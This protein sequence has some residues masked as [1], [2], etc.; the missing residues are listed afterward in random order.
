M[1]KPK[2]NKPQPNRNQFLH[3]IPLKLNGGDCSDLKSMHP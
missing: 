2:K 1:K 3:I